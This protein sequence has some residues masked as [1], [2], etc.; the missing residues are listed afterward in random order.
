MR[1]IL[2]PRRAAAI[3]LRNPDALV[4]DYAGQCIRRGADRA[5][6]GS[7]P[8]RTQMFRIAAALC[9]A[10]GSF[11]SRSD[12]IDLLWGD[13]PDGGPEWS[14]NCVAQMV[15][16]TRP[17]QAWAG[18][19]VVRHRDGRTVVTTA[20][21]AIHGRSLHVRIRDVLPIGVAA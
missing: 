2:A 21:A 12:L 4:V 3:A 1:V 17:F 19:R 16:W 14:W 20:P 11:I 7:G 10:V 8:K 18:L 9:C 13:D 5:V 6:L 15:R